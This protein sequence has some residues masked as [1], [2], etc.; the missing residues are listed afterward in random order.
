MFLKGEFN[1]KETWE[2][3]KDSDKKNSILNN[4]GLLAL[5][6]NI[7]SNKLN[8]KEKNKFNNK[9]INK[10]EINKEIYKGNSPNLNDSIINKKNFFFFFD[11]K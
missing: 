1:I 9:E 3:Q 11:K 5:N 8:G 10:E 7:N 2:Q 4:A 6:G